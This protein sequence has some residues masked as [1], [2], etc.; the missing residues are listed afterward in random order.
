MLSGS[1]PPPRWLQDEDVI[2]GLGSVEDTRR[3]EL[4]LQNIFSRQSLQIYNLWLDGQRRNI[5]EFFHFSLFL[6][7]VLYH[8]I[9]LDGL[10]FV[11]FRILWCLSLYVWGIVS[12]LLETFTDQI[13][14]QFSWKFGAEMFGL[15]RL[16]TME[17]LPPNCL[18]GLG[19]S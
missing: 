4:I 5:L 17:W 11:C 1:K 8:L 15:C 10:L 12:C 2:T 13:I 7:F 6:S 3:G 9:W 19:W 18:V 16:L 14:F